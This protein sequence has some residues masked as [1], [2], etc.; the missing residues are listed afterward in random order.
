MKLVFQ[1]TESYNLKSW[2]QALEIIDLSKN[3]IYLLNNFNFDELTRL[4]SLLNYYMNS[5]KIDFK[6]FSRLDS[7]QNI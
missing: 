5:L 4:T 6:Y 2:I 3:R 1:I 7:M